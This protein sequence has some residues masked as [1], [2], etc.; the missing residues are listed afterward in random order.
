MVGV[1]FGWFWFVFCGV[2]REKVVVLRGFSFFFFLYLVGTRLNSA[3]TRKL[4]V[5]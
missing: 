5:V 3:V 1:G 2:L 4:S